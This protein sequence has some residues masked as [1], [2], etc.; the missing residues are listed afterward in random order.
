M[1]KLPYLQLLWF[2]AIITMLLLSFGP[3]ATMPAE[4][5]S[6]SQFQQWLDEGKIARATV[7]G[8]TIR[9]ELKEKLPNGAA[10]FT[11]QRVPADIAAE[12]TRHGVEYSGAPGM[13]ALGQVLSWI[14]PPLLFV[15]IWIAASRMMAG[16]RGGGGMLGGGCF[17]S[18]AAA[19][20]WWPRPMCARPSTMSPGWTR[21]RRNCTRSWTS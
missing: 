1:R 8:D 5:V 16:G 7:S 21:P 13:G 18:A 3:L 2:M 4:Q 6:Y 17:R 15:G 12:L 14:M 19:L 11:T 20:S 9:G 10:S